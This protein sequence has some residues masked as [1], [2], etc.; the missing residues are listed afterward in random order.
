MVRVAQDPVSGPGREGS[1][2]QPRSALPYPA[3]LGGSG[4]GPQ[5]PGRA[6]GRDDTAPDALRA[7]GCPDEPSA[8]E[9]WDLPDWVAD[10]ADGFAFGGEA[11]A[12]GPGPALAMLVHAAVGG[13]GK[14]LAALSDDQL[15]GVIAAARRLEARVAWTQLAA[16]AEFAARREA[17]P[18]GP[19]QFAADELGSEMGVS[20]QSAAEQMAY[21]R[22][23][24]AR[25]PRTFAAL[26]A[27]LIHPVHLRIIE[28][29]TRVLAD[30]DA[31]KADAELAEAAQS[32]TWGQLRYAAHR[33]VLRLDP[34]AAQRRK[35]AARREAHVRWFREQSG[36][37]GMIARELPADELLATQQHVEQR[38][39]QLRAAGI[40][41]SL[42]ELRV[43]A[44]LDLLT[45]RDSRLATS[46][47]PGSASAPGGP[48]GSAG[49][50]SGEDASGEDASGENDGRDGSGPGDGGPR[51]RD[52]GTGGV[53]PGGRG[54]AGPGPGA[55]R[56]AAG[57]GPSFAALVNVTV[58]L[59]T[60]LGEAAIPGEAAGFG[61]VDAETARDLV[62]AAARHPD[63]RWCVTALRPDGGAAAHACVPGRHGP[64]PPGG[65]GPPGP[66]PPGR[67]PAGFLSG[68]KITFR[69]VIRG[70]CAH[71]QA[72]PGYRPSRS[73]AHLIRARSARCSAPGCGR[74]AVRCDLDHTVAWED[75][76][77]TCCCNLAP[78]CRHHHR[79]KQAGG[80]FLGQPEP[81][82][83]VWRAPTGRTYATVPTTYET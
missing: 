8:E 30:E 13:D 18:P 58:P 82:V 4:A 81:G 3:A 43:R 67:R 20:W 6:G 10:S 69:P 59:S 78:L 35:E 74:P 75:G 71:A 80:W 48:G 14:G 12:M 76:G 70:P 22:A 16:V 40:A 31:A 77:V 34:G 83:L 51:D 7:P 62:A 28:D 19:A 46:D 37:G 21:A 66:A 2:E 54:P 32:K 24:A 5:R 27:G 50:G 60:L 56:G 57:T 45:E 38:A 64:W 44:W 33:L 65:T 52:G 73:L 42:R 9:A 36:N 25:L 53:G 47:G 68:L 1:G 41:G 63:T 39:L 15:L 23:V 29:E 55:A 49:T 72:E 79:L 61:L 17:G 26:A 11:T